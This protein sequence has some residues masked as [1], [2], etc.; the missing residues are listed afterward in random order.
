VQSVGIAPNG[1]VYLSYNQKLVALTEGLVFKW[2]IACGKISGTYNC[3]WYSP[4]IDSRGLVYV[5]SNALSSKLYCFIDNGSSATLKWTRTVTGQCDV[6]SP[7]FGP[8]GQ[9]YAA[10]NNTVYTL[11]NPGS[12][13]SLS[14]NDGSV[15]WT[16]NY[17]GVGPDDFYN[18]VYASVG[19]NGKIYITNIVD[20]S[21][22]VLNDLGNNFGYF[23][24]ISISDS[25]SGIYGSLCL[26]P[27]RVDSGRVFWCNGNYALPGIFAAGIT[28]ITETFDSLQPTATVFRPNVRVAVA[29]NLA[30][31]PAAAPVATL[32]FKMRIKLGNED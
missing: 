16:Y 13:L 11:H 30:L 7:V 21:L 19:D 23:K 8:N 22:V 9:V 27:P 32:P 12:L 1:T 6:L 14:S 2:S 25:D 24:E 28:T 3:D 4:R 31:L 20:S 26:A 5:G 18:W 10:A 29:D 17:S 15:L